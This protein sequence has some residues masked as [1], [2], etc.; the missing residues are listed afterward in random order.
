MFLISLLGC[1][2]ATSFLGQASSS[3][4]AR[5]EECYKSNFEDAYDDQADCVDASLDASEDYYACYIEFCEF[6]AQVASEC[7]SSIR[8]DDCDSYGD[9]CEYDEI[10]SRCDDGDLAECLLDAAF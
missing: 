7:L 3:S 1:V 5:Y 10:Y 8:T 4:C 2:S 9:D 6:D